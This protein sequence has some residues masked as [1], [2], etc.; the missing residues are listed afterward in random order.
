MVGIIAPTTAIYVTR[1]VF[2]PY[3]R[4]SDRALIGIPDRGGPIMQLV[5]PNPNWFLS[6]ARGFGMMSITLVIIDLFARDQR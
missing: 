1:T 5:K 2:E 6:R 4:S 3:L